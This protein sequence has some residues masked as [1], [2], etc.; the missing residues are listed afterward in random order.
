LEIPSRAYQLY[1][2]DGITA[3]QVVHIPK[4][5]LAAKESRGFLQDVQQRIV[6]QATGLYAHTEHDSR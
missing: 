4:V 5:Y 2:L 3:K 1:G 6:T